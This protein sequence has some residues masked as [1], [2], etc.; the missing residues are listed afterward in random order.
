MVRDED[1]GKIKSF[2]Y[3]SKAHST[4]KIDIYIYIGLYAEDFHFLITRAGWLVSHLQ[5][6]MF[7]QSQ[8]K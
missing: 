5:A 1:K 6:F 8:F 4:L 3:S 7:E 2:P